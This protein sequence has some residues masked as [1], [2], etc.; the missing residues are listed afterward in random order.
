[1]VTPHFSLW[2][3]H[4]QDNN[5]YRERRY[6]QAAKAAAKTPQPCSDTA[7]PHSPAWATQSNQRREAAPGASEEEL[8]GRKSPWCSQ[9]SQMDLGNLLCDWV[10]AEQQGH[11]PGHRNA[12]S[13]CQHCCPR[14]APACSP[15]SCSNIPGSL[16]E[17]HVRAQDGCGEVMAAQGQIGTGQAGTDGQGQERQGQDRQGQNR[18]CYK[19]QAT[20][21]PG[22]QD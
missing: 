19:H 6:L 20:P 14:A 22:I 5:I 15:P 3:E 12:Q 4:I 17:V 7:V 21:A 10:C 13:C 9:A 11:C 8:N 2:P 1:M 18:Q 16:Q